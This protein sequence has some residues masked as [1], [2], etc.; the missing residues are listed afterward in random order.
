MAP[1]TFLRLVSKQS[2]RTE[3]IGRKGSP[4]SFE[5]DGCL[6]VRA[7]FRHI[8]SE[9][10]L[11]SITASTKARMVRADRGRVQLPLPADNIR[12]GNPRPP[13]TCEYRYRQKP[14]R[15]RRTGRLPTLARP[16]DQPPRELR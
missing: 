16:R 7:I 11:T 12:R 1:N 8:G 6:G 13:D 9:Y 2:A 4:P 15:C 3:F 10:R 5:A 14:L